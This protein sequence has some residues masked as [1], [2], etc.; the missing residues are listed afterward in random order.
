[1]YPPVYTTLA[2]NS[3]VQAALGTDPRVYPAGDIPLPATTPY[4]VHQT[5]GGS[6]ENYL[7]QTPDADSFLVQ[8]DIYGDDIASVTAAAQ[9]LRDAIEPVAYIVN[10][11]GLTREATP[12]RLYRLS[13]DAEWITPR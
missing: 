12:P 11:R 4:S 10:W 7:G 5:V 8:H 1:M 9:A 6:P 2:A 13:F 3:G